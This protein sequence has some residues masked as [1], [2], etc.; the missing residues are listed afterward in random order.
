[1]TI[2]THLSVPLTNVLRFAFELLIVNPLAALTIAVIFKAVSNVQLRKGCLKLA[3]GI[4]YRVLE[5]ILPDL[6]S[7]KFVKVS[8][9]ALHARSRLGMLFIINLLVVFFVKASELAIEFSFDSANVVARAPAQ[10]N[11]TGSNSN[12]NAG[13]P[14]SS[15]TLES[16]IVSFTALECTTFSGSSIDQGVVI[17]EGERLSCNRDAEPEDLVLSEPLDRVCFGDAGILGGQCRRLPSG[18]DFDTLRMLPDREDLIIIGGGVWVLDNVRRVIVPRPS[19]D[20][21]FTDFVDFGWF[22][23]DLL[24]A[25]SPDPSGAFGENKFVAVG[26]DVASSI[27]LRAYPKDYILTDFWPEPEAWDKQDITLVQFELEDGL[28]TMSVVNPTTDMGSPGILNAT[29][30]GRAVHTLFIRPSDEWLWEPGWKF[31]DIPDYF[32]VL[33]SLMLRQSLSGE[34]ESFQAASLDRKTERKLMYSGLR[35]FERNKLRISGE[36]FV[37]SR[38]AGSRRFEKTV[39]VV[40]EYGLI[41]LGAVVVV[42]VFL[43][44]SVKVACRS[45]TS[46]DGSFR[47]MVAR[48]VDSELHRAQCLKPRSDELVLGVTRSE[49]GELHFGAVGGGLVVTPEGLKFAH[50]SGGVRRRGL[51]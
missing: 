41:L 4:V 17:T 8:N 34:P 2:T 10:F 33:R 18:S 31:R 37:A 27:K 14:R 46:F 29:L 21:Q 23:A 12:L 30:D 36:G 45:V 48:L 44:V 39:T 51:R 1:M 32:H 11:I 42:L 26:G 40:E 15:S 24:P 38:R 35:Y 13:L 50:G 7:F 43:W 5:A 28:L 49:A 16:E 3:P 22:E 20:E 19:D 47:D 6:R 9:G 25:T